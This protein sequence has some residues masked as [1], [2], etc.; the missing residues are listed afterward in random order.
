MPE[1]PSRAVEHSKE[2]VQRIT[3]TCL[4]VEVDGRP[5]LRRNASSNNL[6]P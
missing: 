5:L 6:I 2:Q 1:K 3:A 4:Y